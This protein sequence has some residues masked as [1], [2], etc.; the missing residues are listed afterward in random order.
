MT[1]EE[2]MEPCGFCYQYDYLAVSNNQV[3]C[4]CGARGPFGSTEEEAVRAWNIRLVPI[5]AVEKA[6]LKVEVAA[7][8]AA[9]A[10][11]RT[12][13]KNALS[14]LTQYGGIDGAHHKTWTIDQAIRALCGIPNGPHGYPGSELSEEYLTH[15][16]ES[17]KGKD[18]TAWEYTWD[19][20]VAP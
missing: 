17:C 15:I 11:S 13:V 8:L 1:T 4:P 6:G 14:I 2:H 20:G 19:E 5:S 7:S 10:E 12:R 18:G 16:Y 3:V 9:G